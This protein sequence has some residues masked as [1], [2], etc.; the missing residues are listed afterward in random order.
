MATAT[1]TR[2]MTF[3]EFSELSEPQGSRYEL[4]HGELII[5]APPTHEHF[6]IQRHLRRLLENAAQGAGEVEIEMAFQATSDY[7]Y[8]IADVAF[9]SKER[10]AQIP[11][12]GT[13]RGAPDLVIE[14]LSPSNTATEILDKETLCLENGSKEFWVVDVERQQVK[15]STPDGRTVTYKSGATIPL[16]FG[17][18]IHVKEIFTQP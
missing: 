11:L 15:V 14:V 8:R 10:W 7:N 1:Q 18:S 16:F 6:L 12:K 4:R 17:G 2:L 13:M 3:S 9:I 5:L